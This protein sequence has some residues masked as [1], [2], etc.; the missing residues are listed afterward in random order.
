[1]TSAEA[2]TETAT[3]LAR[4]FVE[5]VYNAGDLALLD[6]LCAPDYAVHDPAVPQAHDVAG[7][8]EAL[9]TFRFTAM[10]DLRM[11]IEDLIAAGDRV[12]VRWTARGTMTGELLGMAPTGKA[13]TVAGMTIHRVANGKLAETWWNWDALGMMQQLGLLPM[14]GDAATS[15]ANG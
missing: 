5:E 13:T 6:E 3:T 14:P 7:Y 4:R 2:T 9:Q 8:K 1:M 12:T 11:T 10:P 15:N